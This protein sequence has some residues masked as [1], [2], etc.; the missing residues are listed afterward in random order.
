MRLTAPADLRVQYR[1]RLGIVADFSYLPSAAVARLRANPGVAI[2]ICN[3][4]NGAIKDLGTAR[5]IRKSR[6]TVQDLQLLRLQYDSR[7]CIV[8]Q[9][10]SNVYD[11]NARINGGV[12]Q[13]LF[14]VA[15]RTE[16][17]PAAPLAPIAPDFLNT[18]P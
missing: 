5:D 10:G 3:A 13:N 4:I 7:G 8:S 17:S 12:L 1:L 14:V 9:Y 2:R 11:P 18:T 15:N 6:L 16:D